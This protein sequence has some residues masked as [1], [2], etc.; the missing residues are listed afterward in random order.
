MDKV[1]PADNPGL[2]LGAVWCLGWGIVVGALVGL[3]TLFF[4]AFRFYKKADGTLAAVSSKQVN[5]E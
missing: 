5:V 3:G 1:A 4:T 2:V